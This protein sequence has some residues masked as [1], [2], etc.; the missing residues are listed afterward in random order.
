MRQ[1]VEVRLQSLQEGNEK[2]LEQMRATV[3]EKLQSHARAAAGRELQAGRRS[4]R[5][6]AQG[7]GR[8]AGPGAR[9]RLAQPRAEQREDARHLRRGAARRAARTGVH[10]RAVRA[11]TSRPVP[12]SG[13]RVEFAIRLPGSATDGVP[14]WLPIDAE[15]P[16]RGLRAPARCAGARRPGGRRGGRPR[17]SRRGCAPRPR[18]SAT[19]YLAPPHT[20]DFAHPA[21]CP[22]RACTPRRCA[23]R[24]WSRRCSASTRVMLAGPDHAAGHA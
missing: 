24:A 17:R 1:A 6:G 14:L 8:D 19:K 13:A 23:G 16:A 7:P 22:P 20:T 4:A 10:A 15:V 11:P 3:D 5:A 2:K 21:S 12:G 9:R 18:R